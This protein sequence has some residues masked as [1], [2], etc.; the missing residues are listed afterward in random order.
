M[1]ATLSPELTIRTAVF[2]KYGIHDDLKLDDVYKPEPEDDGVLIKVRAASINDWDYDRL[3]GRSL[4]SRFVFGLL[5]PRKQRLGCDVAG[6]VE[7]VG[8]RANEFK[9]G[10]DVYGDLSIAGFGA[11]SEYVSVPQ[12]ALCRK[13]AGMSFEQAA[14]IPQAAVLAV[15][16]LIDAGGL[17]DGYSVLING[18]GG[19]VG[20]IGLQIA[21]QR[22][23]EVT[24]V[25]SHD[26][27][28]PLRNLGFDQVIDYR[29]KDFTEAGETYDLIVDVKTDR[30]TAHYLRSLN[31]NGTYVTVGGSMNRLFAV[32]VVGLAI[33]PFARKSLRV[34]ALD[35]NKH[36]GYMNELFEA[37]KFEPVIDRV[38]NFSDLAAALDY[39]GSKKF[40][41]KVLV[42]F[43]G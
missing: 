27:L 32:L 28:E 35:A 34:V 2:R 20:T 29:Q 25:D 40:V 16:A 30:P 24:G 15:Q 3:H 31:P 8:S 14:A 11:F 23:V 36:L 42:A 21:K 26:K 19:G 18:A 41:G 10:D 4:I 13:P 22:D 12:A 17:R 33:R 37:G 9:P 5:K 6:T 39:Y 7:S 1:I 38:F 43:D